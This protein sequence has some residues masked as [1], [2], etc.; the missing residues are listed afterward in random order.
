MSASVDELVERL[1]SRRELPRA[2]ERR[3]IRRAAG[4]SMRDVGAAIGVSHTAVRKW[5]AGSM[6]RAPHRDAYAR[7]LDELKRVAA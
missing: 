7:L 3:R 1:R 4:A 6:P 5:E 2:S